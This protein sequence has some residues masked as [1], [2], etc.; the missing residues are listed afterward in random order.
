MPRVKPTTTYTER[1]KPT[2]SWT[3]PRLNIIPLTADTTLYTADSTLLTA[4]Q[5]GF[6]TE[7]K[8]EYTTPRS[9]PTLL[10]WL[11]LVL[12]DSSWLRLEWAWVEFA[13]INTL[14]TNWT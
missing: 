6:I 10:D 8:T 3:T 13:E 12:E 4:D 11:W 7:I 2:S 14:Q 9:A 5:T 1:V